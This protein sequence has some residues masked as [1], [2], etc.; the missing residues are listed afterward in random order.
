MPL[1]YYRLCVEASI[2]TFPCC[3]HDFGTNF[4][5][6]KGSFL[7]SNGAVADWLAVPTEASKVGFKLLMFGPVL[8]NGP[9]GETAT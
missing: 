8:D 9:V 7:Y 6:G 5:Q 4:C 3:F 2:R 1:Y